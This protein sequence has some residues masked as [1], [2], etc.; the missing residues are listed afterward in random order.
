MKKYTIIGGVNGSGKSSLTG[1]LGGLLSDLGTVIDAD[2][3]T[4]RL[5]GDRLTGGKKAVGL[6]SDCLE[7]GVNFTQETTLSGKKTLQTVTRAK[8]LDYYIRLYYVGVST[9]EESVLR[10]K[11]RVRKGGHDIPEGDVLRRFESRFEDLK[12]ILPYC[13]EVHFYDNENGFAEVGEYRNGRVIL[14]GDNVPEW[15]SGFKKFMERER[16]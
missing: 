11:N 2:S 15:I 7:R 5:G 14:F 12:K 8:E 6:I 3:I 9:A 16:L 1:V 4:A 13:D 10:I